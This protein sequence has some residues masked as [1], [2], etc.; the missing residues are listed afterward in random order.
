MFSGVKPE[1][2]LKIMNKDILSGQM[3]AK[4]GDNY[5]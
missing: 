2:T 5:D 4:S 1:R 3:G